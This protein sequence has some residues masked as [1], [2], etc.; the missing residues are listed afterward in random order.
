[1]RNSPGTSGGRDETQARLSRNSNGDVA[2]V[3]RVASRRPRYY[4]HDGDHYVERSAVLD[5]PRGH[6]YSVSSRLANVVPSCGSPAAGRAM[7]F[8]STITM[9][10]PP[11]GLASV[12][13]TFMAGKSC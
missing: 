2:N 4:E 10:W 6:S 3:L 7:M 8:Q 9:V 5:R 13:G 12:A 1:M 11:V